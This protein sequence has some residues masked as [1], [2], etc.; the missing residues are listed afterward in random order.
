LE[1]AI[2]QCIQAAG[3]E[4][5]PSTQKML[6]RAASFGKCFMPELDPEPFVTMCKT[7]RV[8]NAIRDHALGIP[9]TYAQLESLTLDVLIDR[10]VLRRH[11]Y[12]AIQV[13]KY[14]RIPDA[15]GTSKILSHWAKYKVMQSHLDEDQ[16]AREIAE[17]VGSTAGVSYS[18]IAL[19]ASN[20]GKKQL[21]TKLLDYESQASR[22]VPL[23]LTLKEYQ[24]AVSKAIES[25][26]TDLIFSVVLQLSGVLSRADFLT[27]IKKFPVAYTLYLKYCRT[28]NLKE[29][30]NL[31]Y[32]EDNFQAQGNICV[33]ESY[34]KTAVDE[35]I[36]ELQTVLDAYRKS[37]NDF[38]INQTED[39]IRLLRNQRSI[40]EKFHSNTYIG[41]SLH[42]TLTLLLHERQFKLAEE[43]RKTFKV[44]DKRYC[45]TKVQAFA[46]M[47]EWTELEKIGKKSPIGY[48]PLVDACMRKNNSHEARKYL[49][50]VLNANKI[51]YYVK[52]GCLEE[53]SN[54][55]L[56]QKDELG[57][58]YVQ[59]KCGVSNKA[60]ADKIQCMKLQ[61][62]SKR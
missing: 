38:L 5:L 4:Y 21:A 54:I 47:G 31:Y 59:L 20:S 56:E 23:L 2:T 33:I 48:E 18:D 60:L 17:K 3:H 27:T 40:S 12:L 42:E 6:L 19:D 28:E 24:P 36:A 57:L 26:D 61:L 10:L 9:L 35:R 7:L 8:L 25:G 32:Q 41:K 16:V 58:N 55:A 11:Y 46:D 15:K 1:D 30:S 53:A 37:R 52:A 51:K 22:Q 44:S 34:Q 49:P 29:L 45:W 43:L 14:L 39:Q 13:C 50:K 62:S